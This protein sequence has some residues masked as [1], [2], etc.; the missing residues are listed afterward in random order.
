MCSFIL[1]HREIEV[2]AEPH[3]CFFVYALAVISN[4][5]LAGPCTLHSRKFLR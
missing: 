3:Y 4:S 1:T 5:L 2:L